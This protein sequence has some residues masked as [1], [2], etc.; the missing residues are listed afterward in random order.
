M[1]ME[2]GKFRIFRIGQQVWDSE[3]L[4]PFKSKAEAGRILSCLGRSVLLFKPSAG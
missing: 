1:L 2:A 3:P 4:L